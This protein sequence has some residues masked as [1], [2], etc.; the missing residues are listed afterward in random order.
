MAALWLE[1]LA[2]PEINITGAQARQLMRIHRTYVEQFGFTLDEL[3]HVTRDTL[4]RL[5][6]YVKDK[7]KEIAQ[8]FL[9]RV[10]GLA[11]ADL[12][13]VCR[14]LDGGEVVEPDRVE[15]AIPDYN[16]CVRRIKAKLT[17]EEMIMVREHPERVPL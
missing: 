6:P 1:F 14:E 4:D 17:P 11:Q 3:H 9:E 7:T 16:Q 5:H 2:S 8:A 12:K 13:D 10:D 15:R